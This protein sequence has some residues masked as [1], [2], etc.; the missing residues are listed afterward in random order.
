MIR[1]PPPGICDRCGQRFLHKDLVWEMYK[2]KRTGLL[3]CKKCNGP[4]HPQEYTENVRTNDRQSVKDARSDKAELPAV[5]SLWS[6]AP[7]GANEATGTITTF[8]GKATVN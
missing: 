5:R 4:T 7:A 2:G 6:W 8:I 3:T 1:K